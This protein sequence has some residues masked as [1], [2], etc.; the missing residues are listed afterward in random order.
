MKDIHI[1]DTVRAHYN[2][3]TY[4]GKVLEDRGKHFFDRDFSC[5]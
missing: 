5:I 4:I 1:G 2:S 3:G